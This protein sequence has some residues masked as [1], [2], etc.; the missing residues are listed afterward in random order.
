MASSRAA[1][2]SPFSHALAGRCILAVVNDNWHSI[3]YVYA[4]IVEPEAVQA[5]LLTMDETCRVAAN[6]AK[7]PALLGARREE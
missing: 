3:A 6:I 2:T 5:Q 1:F 7:L 4:K